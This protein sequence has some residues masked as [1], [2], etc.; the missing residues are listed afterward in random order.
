MLTIYSHFIHKR[1]R[2]LNRILSS[3]IQFVVVGIKF[4]NFTI[5]GTFK[6]IPLLSLTLRDFDSLIDNG[7]HC[8]ML[9]YHQK[10]ILLLLILIMLPF[11]TIQ[12]ITLLN[13]L[14]LLVC[15]FRSYSFRKKLS[16]F[17]FIEMN[18][19]RYF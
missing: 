14:H 10:F 7:M 17:L 8:I 19:D 9:H 15:H 4:L 2:T 13:Q 6:F 3:Q 1:A 5:V 12:V 18:F 11:G 16:H